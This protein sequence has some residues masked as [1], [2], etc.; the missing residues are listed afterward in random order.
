MLRAGVPVVKAECRHAASEELRKALLQQGLDV[1]GEN[2]TTVQH[3][4]VAGPPADEQFAVTNE[5]EISGAE[6]AVPGGFAGYLCLDIL[7]GELRLAPIAGSLART[8]DP[9]LADGASRRQ[10]CTFDGFRA[11]WVVRQFEIRSN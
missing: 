7:H 3:Q 8:V 11:D 2:V 9:D 4:H 5:A 10:C 1:A 6:V